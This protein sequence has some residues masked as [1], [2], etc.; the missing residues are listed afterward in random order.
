MP[1]PK[2]SLEIVPHNPEG[3]KGDEDINHHHATHHLEG[4]Q[5]SGTVLDSD[6]FRGLNLSLSGIA[7]LCDILRGLEEF[8]EHLK[9]LGAD[10]GGLEVFNTT[11]IGAT[12]LNGVDPTVQEFHRVAAGNLMITTTIGVFIGSLNST[13]AEAVEAEVTGLITRG[14]GD[15]AGEA[16]DHDLSP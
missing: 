10:R 6:F 15:G 11:A 8:G 4:V 12:G 2:D 7:V 13:V 9:E 5:K 16:D 14:K 3:Y 1:L